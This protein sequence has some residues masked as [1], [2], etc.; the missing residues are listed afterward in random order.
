MKNQDTDLVI[1]LIAGIEVRHGN[2]LRIYF[3]NKTNLIKFLS[4]GLEYKLLLQDPVTEQTLKESAYASF[5][6]RGFNRG[7]LSLYFPY[8]LDV[9]P[10]KLWISKSNV[11]WKIMSD[12]H[13]QVPVVLSEKLQREEDMITARENAQPVRPDQI[14]KPKA[15]I[16]RNHLKLLV[17]H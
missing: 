9:T 3:A 11:D 17:S 14:S 10:N 5:V 8:D 15:Q 12:V 7:G 2:M 4:L 1:S 16:I 13:V 6:T